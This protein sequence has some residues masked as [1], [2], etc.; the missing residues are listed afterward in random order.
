MRLRKWGLRI[1]VLD[2]CFVITKKIAIFTLSHLQIE[3]FI[4]LDKH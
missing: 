1:K 2:F 3:Y 4:V